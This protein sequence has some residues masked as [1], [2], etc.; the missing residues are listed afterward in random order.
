MW[1]A[2]RRLQFKGF[3]HAPL[4]LHPLELLASQEISI[5]RTSKDSRSTSNVRLAHRVS[6]SSPRPLHSPLP[7]FLTLFPHQHPEDQ[8]E[9]SSRRPPRLVFVSSSRLSSVHSFLLGCPVVDEAMRSRA[10]L[11]GEVGEVGEGEERGAKPWPRPHSLTYPYFL[12]DRDFLSLYF[13]R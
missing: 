2:T 7:I 11:S 1:I 4:P 3:R 12:S 6:S 13:L 10:I 9:T 8:N 5:L